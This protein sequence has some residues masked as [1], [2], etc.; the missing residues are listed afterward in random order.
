ML[1]DITYSF[2]WCCGTTRALARTTRREILD[3]A[4]PAASPPMAK[5]DGEEA[6]FVQECQTAVDVERHLWDSAY[7]SVADGN[8][9][10]DAIEYLQSLLD[11]VASRN[12]YLQTSWI[13]W[14]RRDIASRTSTRMLLPQTVASTRAFP[15]CAPER[16]RSRL[17]VC[18]ALSDT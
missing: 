17:L 15:L 18:T 6:P 7:G 4:R 11:D 14:L 10:F 13:G 5:L 2:C 8:I 16:S 9:S 12:S 3:R 1:L